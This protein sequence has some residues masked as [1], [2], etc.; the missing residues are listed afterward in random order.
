MVPFL[1]QLLKSHRHICGIC[2]LA[3]QLKLGISKRTFKLS[4]VPLHSHQ[5]VATLI[6]GSKIEVAY[7]Y[8][9]FTDNLAIRQGLWRLD[10]VPMAAT[11]SCIL[12]IQKGLL[13]SVFITISS[14]KGN[15][16]RIGRLLKD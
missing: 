15:H 13:M 1:Y 4:T 14:F 11:L 10:K 7:G 8:L 3:I 2:S 6:G 9:L 12:W 5:W 16:K